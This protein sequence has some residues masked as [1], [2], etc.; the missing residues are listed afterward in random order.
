LLRARGVQ[1]TGDLLQI[2]FHSKGAKNLG[3]EEFNTGV[4]IYD[5]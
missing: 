4:S 1:L 2:P 5:L 3:L